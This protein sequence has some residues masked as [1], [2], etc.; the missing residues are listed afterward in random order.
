M[1]LII[2]DTYL[3]YPGPWDLSTKKP[4]FKYG[5]KFHFQNAIIKTITTTKR[6]T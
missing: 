3:G 2:L 5:E 1:V 6:H 4:D